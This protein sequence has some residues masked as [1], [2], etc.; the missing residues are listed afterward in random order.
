MPLV[1]MPL[2][3][4][5]SFRPEVD[6]PADFDAFWTA[7]LAE[8]AAAG[9][10]VTAARV[11]AALTTLDVYDVTFPGFAGEP[12]KAWY[13][14]PRGAEDVPLVVEYIGYGGGRGLPLDR[15]VWASAGFGHLVVDSRGQ[16]GSWGSGAD[17]ADA[18]GA[19]PAHPGF[20]TRGIL[21]PSDHYYRRLITDAARAID[22]APALPG[23]DPERIVLTGV[24][25]GG[26]L[27]IAAA[28]LRP[29]AIRAT[30]PD[31]AFLCHIRRGAL[32]SDVDP[33]REIAD[34]LAVRRDHADQ[35]FRTLSYI[36][37][38]NFAKRA[39]APSLWSV[40]LMDNCCPPSTTFT[41]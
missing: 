13:L 30:M 14:K 17:T 37:A 34:Y 28:G 2:D 32:I 21:D 24:S 18:H 22:A 1:D 6:E 39:L 38:V 35:V 11:D 19:G 36:D 41:A 10:D 29:E 25:Q 9:G 15:L 4:L 33:Y 16:G 3:Q 12:I 23:A 40:G 20:M 7:T 5:E 8:S 27:A 31:V 26:G